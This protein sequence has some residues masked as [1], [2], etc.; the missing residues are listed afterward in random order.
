MNFHEILDVIRYER[1]L[2][3]SLADGHMGFQR[4][5]TTIGDYCSF[6]HGTP[7]F[8]LIWT[9]LTYTL[10]YIP[11]S[12]T[13]TGNN[14]L[15]SFRQYYSYGSLLDM[16]PAYIGAL[17]EWEEVKGLVDSHANKV[18][19][20]GNIG[21]VHGNSILAVARSWK[22][23]DL[24]AYQITLIQ[25]SD[26]LQCINDTFVSM[27]KCMDPE[28]FHDKNLYEWVGLLLNQV[29]QE[30]RG[31]QSQREQC[32]ILSTLVRIF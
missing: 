27:H 26:L 4:A 29:E 11:L 22:L 20:K 2:L 5:H 18:I 8:V 7:S 30:K 14:F 19:S 16:A 23:Q 3:R 10:I 12:A 24:A 28:S 6:Y 25:C 17:A 9:Q 32:G 1:H 13:S 31:I 21:E 15:H